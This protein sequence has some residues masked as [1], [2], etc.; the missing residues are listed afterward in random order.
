MEEFSSER[1]NPN[2]ENSPVMQLPSIM[3]T[4]DLSIL[5][6]DGLVSMQKTGSSKDHVWP[7]GTTIIKGIP[8][9]EYKDIVLEERNLANQ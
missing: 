6:E 4:T 2:N 3:Q 5:T 9:N 7:L 8:D 1:E